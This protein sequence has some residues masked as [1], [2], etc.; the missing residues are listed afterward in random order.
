MMFG[1]FSKKKKEKTT[2]DYK[3]FEVDNKWRMYYICP[4]CGAFERE[5]VMDYVFLSHAMGGEIIP[6]G[7]KYFSNMG[8]CEKCGT[9]RLKF[10]LKPMRRNEQGEIE[11]K[12][13]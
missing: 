10:E 2:L 6:N 3:P 7:R 5:W 13:T 8:C 4:E 1:L 12:K 9:L 11:I